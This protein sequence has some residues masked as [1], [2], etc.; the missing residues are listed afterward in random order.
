MSFYLPVSWDYAARVR[1]VDKK[2]SFP[3]TLNREENPDKTNKRADSVRTAGNLTFHGCGKNPPGGIL[4]CLSTSFR[5]GVRQHRIRIRLSLYRPA[6]KCKEDGLLRLP[7]IPRVFHKG[8][9]GSLIFMSVPPD[10]SAGG[11]RMTRA[12]FAKGTGYQH[13]FTVSQ[14]CLFPAGKR[15]YAACLK[16]G[17]VTGGRKPGRMLQGGAG[18]YSPR[19][20]TARLRRGSL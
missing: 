14:L 9:G 7:Y 15:E 13:S 5:A 16:S 6:V 4:T 12:L 8:R 3:V 19:V 2:I 10:S 18:C 11:T 1:A 17:T 20:I